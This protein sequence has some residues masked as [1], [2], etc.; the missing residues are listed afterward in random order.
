MGEVAEV[1]E[2]D[3]VVAK[4]Q[5]RVVIKFPRQSQCKFPGSSA[6]QCRGRY[7][8]RTA[9][10]PPGRAASK[11]PSRTAKVYPCRF[12]SSSGGRSKGACVRL[13]ILVTMVE[14]TME[15]GVFLA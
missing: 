14:G 12:Q 15:V 3:R 6:R 10:R 9:S 7:P 1:V 4:C 8:S 11:C 13:L 2:V 5:G